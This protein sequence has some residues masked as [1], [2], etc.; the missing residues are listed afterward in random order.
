MKRLLLSAVLVFAAAPAG[1]PSVAGPLPEIRGQYV[2]A[3]TCDVYTGPCFANA[4]TGLTGRHAVV[5]WKIESGAVGSTRIDGLG[6]VAVVAAPETLGLKQS[7]PGK[8]ILIVDAKANAAQRAALVAFVKSEVGDLAREVVAVRSAPVDLTICPCEGNS[9]ATLTA[10]A[11]HITT[12][13]LNVEHDKAC[14]N[15]VAFFPPLAKGVSAKPGN[16]RR[17]QLHWPGSQRDLERQRA[18]RCLRRVVREQ[19]LGSDEHR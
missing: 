17:T 12:R 4:D 3:R 5:A 15:E 8:A 14:G 10:G 6:V 9:C 13:C 18:P 2:E 1:A 16:G 11:A 7:A 19:E